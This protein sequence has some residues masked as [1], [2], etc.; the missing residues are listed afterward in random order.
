MAQLNILQIV[1]AAVEQALVEVL[2]QARVSAVDGNLIRITR[3]GQ[4]IPDP[5]AYPRLEHVNV[6]VGS[7]V[8]VARV[9]NGYVI[10]GE[11]VR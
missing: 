1:R 8:L 5:Q 9:G 7:Y 11:I 3:T 4:T 10:V 2:F 6:G